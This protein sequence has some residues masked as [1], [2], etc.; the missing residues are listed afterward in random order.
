MTVS[1]DTKL[2]TPIQVGAVEL[3]HRVVLAPLTRRR[4]S[5][6][7]AI[8]ADFAADYYS[9]RASGMFLSFLLL[10]LWTRMFTDWLCF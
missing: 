8:P 4:A 1:N 5:A 2:F 3:K 10:C 6:G 7:T 9:Q